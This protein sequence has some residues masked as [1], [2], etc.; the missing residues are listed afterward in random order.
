M[1]P[2]LESAALKFVMHRFAME[3]KKRLKRKLRFLASCKEKERARIKLLH[4]A[5]GRVMCC[6]FLE[7][8]EEFY[9]V[10]PARCEAVGDSVM[11][12]VDVRDSRG[13]NVL[14]IKEEMEGGRNTTSG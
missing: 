4:R 5:V 13:G 1:L 9:E 3:Q 11:E 6:I 8:F 12:Q 2:G 7:A 10:V 14:R